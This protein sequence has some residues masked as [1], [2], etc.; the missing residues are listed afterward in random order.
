MNKLLL[1]LL[2]TISLVI[3]V[4]A[5][6]ADLTPQEAYGRIFSS[7]VKE[8]SDYFSKDFLN[9]IPPE[10]I[11]EISKIY[12]DAIG[13]YQE[14]RSSKTGYRLIFAKGEADSKISINANN[15]ISSLWFG[16]PEYT[17][18]TLDAVKKAFKKLPGEIS[19]CVMQHTPDEES[20]TELL[21]LNPDQPLACGS[22]F[23]L[24]IL[25]ALVESI[26]KG[27]RAWTDL[28]ELRDDWKSFPSGILQEWP[29]GSRH[30]LETLT[31]LMISISDNTATDHIYNLIGAEKL[32]KHF[33]ASCKDL[34]N[35]SQ[36]LK[37]KFF[38][39]EQAKA[40]LKANA[41]GKQKILADIDAIKPGDIAS[42][43]AIYELNEPMLVEELEWFV[44]TRE[45]C[46]TIYSLRNNQLIRINPATGLANK[47]DWHLIGYKGGSEPGVLNY[48]WVLQKSPTS[49][50]YTVSATVVNSQK[51]VDSNE[52][53]VIVT[54]LLALLKAL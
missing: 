51:P 37:L 3:P 28:V 9:M 24:F 44:S 47:K 41:S 19:V 54:R 1:A 31:G 40:Y 34:F 29:A 8:L 27:E 45:L 48:T 39:P 35:T 22:S 16:A 49:P 43:S 52:F 20:P 21:Q 12:V 13:P 42:L 38:F 7:D 23:K 15:K 33:P 6:T 5:D 26:N 4:W 50:F 46:K 17:S 10:K 53:S 14:A 30:T 32:R 2:I 36:M 18:D 25:K 11:I